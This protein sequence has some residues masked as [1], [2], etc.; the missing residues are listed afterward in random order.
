[1]SQIKKTLAFS[2]EE[3][4]GRLDRV[5]KRMAE[6]GLDGLVVTTPENICYLSG[7]H[8]SGYYFVQ[9]LLVA[10]DREPKLVARLF[11]QR[12]IDAYSWLDRGRH[13]VAYTDADDP[14]QEIARTLADL[15]LE[16]GRIGVDLSSFFLPVDKYEDLKARL[17]NAKLCNGYGIVEVER[18]V[19]SPAEVEVIRRACRVSE[20]GMRAMVEHARP[21]ITENALAGEIHKAL[22]GNGSEYP[23]LPVF[24]A[25]GWRSEIPHA[26]WSD[27]V[28]EKGEVVFC[29]LTGVVNRYSGPLLRCVVLGKPT[30]D[31]ARRAAV[32][33]EMLEAALKAIRPGVTSGAVNAA[34]VAVAEKAGMGA[35]AINRAGY[36]I[37]INFPPD[38]GEGS[39]L[40]LKH[41]DPTVLE[42]GMTFHV[43]RSMRLEGK[44]ALSISESVLVTEKGCE[45]LTRFEPR[46]LIV[47]A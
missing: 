35:G 28:I 27:K 40:D 24:L 14:M 39:F 31:L 8:T 9:A 20:A 33:E 34:V 47:K 21:G 26:N 23:G 5:R 11:E 32:C 42:P 43:P 10:R 36:S 18:K 1:M 16:R 6:K 19:K 44:D 37:G 45:A 22:I 3:Y 12:N 46:K 25:S 17:P 15:G 4:K 2:V 41:G 7:Y 38:W 13:G 30:E 29:E